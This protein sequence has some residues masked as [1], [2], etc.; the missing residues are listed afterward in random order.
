[1]PNQSLKLTE[2]AVDDLVARE[3]IFKGMATS[4]A[5]IVYMELAARRRS[6]AP[7]RYASLAAGEDCSKE[8]E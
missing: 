8:N 2:P 1:V 6:L 4:A 7:V 3:N 5:R